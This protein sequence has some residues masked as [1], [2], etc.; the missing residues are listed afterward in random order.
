MVP[1]LPVASTKTATP[2][3]AVAPLTPARYVSVW[4]LPMRMVFDSLPGA[5]LPT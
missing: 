2:P 4:V 1:S 3:D 5:L